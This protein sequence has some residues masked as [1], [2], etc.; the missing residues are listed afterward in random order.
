MLQNKEWKRVKFEDF[1]KDFGIEVV[2]NNAPTI[3]YSKKDKEPEAFGS[4]VLFFF[5]VGALLIY[6]AISV[7]LIPLFFNIVIFIIVLV[8]GSISAVFLLINYLRSSTRIKPKECWIEIF[9]H[10]EESNRSYYCFKYYPIFSGKAYPNKAIN[11]IYKLFQEHNLSTTIDISEIEIYLSYVNGEASKFDIIGYFFPYG[12]GIP[13]KQESVGGAVW[14]FFAAEKYAADN[15]LATA[16]WAHQYEWRYD[17]ALDFDKLNSYA[18]WVIQ[19][20][21][22]NNLK[23]LTKEVKS[24][25]KWDLRGLSKSPGLEPWESDFEKKTIKE[26]KISKQLI[27]VEEAINKIIGK[28]QKI[29]KIKEIKEKIPEFEIYFRDLS[30]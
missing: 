21:N 4:L 25:I 19:R 23:P 10:L 8:I 28:N 12:E 22:A 18:P 16:N 7:I 9:K 6:I 2:I 24:R 15:Y 27:F 3:L 29:E 17:L 30:I 26:K 13:F 1:I 5:L 20:W 14:K 11:I